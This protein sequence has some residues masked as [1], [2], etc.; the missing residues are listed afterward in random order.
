M[1]Q[2]HVAE[3]LLAFSYGWLVGICVSRWMRR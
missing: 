3:L 1:T 2:A